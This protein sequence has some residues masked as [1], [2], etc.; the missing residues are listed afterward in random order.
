MPFETCNI[1]VEPTIFRVGSGVP[2]LVGTLS[3]TLTLTPLF[4]LR[5]NLPPEISPLIRVL[6][7]SLSSVSGDLYTR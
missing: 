7:Q 5:T 3:L 1:I 6:P 2:A 4:S